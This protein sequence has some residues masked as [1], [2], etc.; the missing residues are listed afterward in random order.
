MKL[1]PDCVRMKHEIQKKLAE[2]FK[3]MSEA[4]IRAEQR[5]RIEANPIFGSLAK[6]WRVVNPDSVETGGK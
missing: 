2:D 6:K 5:R 1:Y 4:E 3:G